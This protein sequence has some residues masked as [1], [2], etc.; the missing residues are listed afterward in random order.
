M[1]SLEIHYLVLNYT[2]TISLLDEVTRIL[3]NENDIKNDNV[4]K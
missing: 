1:A 3:A 4:Y 2:K